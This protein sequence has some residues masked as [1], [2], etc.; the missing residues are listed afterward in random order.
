M[1]SSASQAEEVIPANRVTASVPANAAPSVF[2][3][4]PLGGAAYFNDEGITLGVYAR[5]DD[6]AISKVEFLADGVTLGELTSGPFLWVWPGPHG[7]GPHTVY[8]RVFDNSGQST[9]TP[10]STIQIQPLTVPSTTLQATTGPGGEAGVIYTLQTMIP[11]GR[12]YVIEWTSNMTDWNPLRSGTST[13]ALI[14][15]IDTTVGAGKRFYRA[16]LTN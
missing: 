8:A 6:G 11:A 2:F 3:S 5:D 15:V 9:V 4:T 13:G 7:N 16:R 1:W 10:I 14:E 12:A